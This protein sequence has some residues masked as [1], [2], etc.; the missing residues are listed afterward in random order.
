MGQREG[1]PPIGPGNH[2]LEGEDPDVRRLFRL[3]G[4]LVEFKHEQLRL[5]R[6]TLPGLSEVARQ[7]ILTNDVLGLEEEL[8]RA[9]SRLRFWSRRLW[10][11]MDI[12]V[13][14][15][16]LEVQHAGKS[17]RLTKRECELA[18]E[19]W[20]KPLSGEELRLYVARLRR[21]LRQAHLP[22][23]LETRRGRSYRLL[24]E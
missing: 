1:V 24:P 20:G 6:R 3:Y 23:R 22:V 8:R 9:R 12:A 4:E 13:D 15:E 2:L 10:E 18:Q 5:T 19:A 7:E 16:R 17:V 11:L 21:K 14:G